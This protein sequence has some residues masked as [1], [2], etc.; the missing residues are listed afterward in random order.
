[1]LADFDTEAIDVPLV[2]GKSVS[3]VNTALPWEDMMQQCTS[4]GWEYVDLSDN[5]EDELGGK[6]W[7]PR[8]PNESLP[9]D[10][11]SAQVRAACHASPKLYRRISGL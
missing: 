1:M 11:C 10:L 7:L 5:G 9:D 4:K 6:V 8:Y 2:V 3:G